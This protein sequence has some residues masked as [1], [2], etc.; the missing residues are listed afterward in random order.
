VASALKDAEPVSSAFF[1]AWKTVHSTQAQ[2]QVLLAVVSRND[3]DAATLNR[4]TQAAAQMQSQEDQLAV[5]KAIAVR[6]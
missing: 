5:L 4:V 6:R 3:L 2:R 1:A